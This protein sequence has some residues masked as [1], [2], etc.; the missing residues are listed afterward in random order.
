MV[1]IT[2]KKTVSTLF[3]AIIMSSS[4]RSFSRF[5]DFFL[6]CLVVGSL[7]IRKKGENSW[8]DHLLSL[9]VIGCHSL[10]LV[11]LLVVT[12]CI[13]RLSFFKQSDRSCFYD[14]YDVNLWEKK[15]TS[16]FVE[17][18]PFTEGVFNSHRKTRMLESLCRFSGLQ[19]Y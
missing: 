5:K 2:N 15:L 17:F 8:N 18:N 9:I 6:V 4:S 13:T 3:I 14:A 7:F 19:F 12:R 10:S 11:V 1:Y 16:V